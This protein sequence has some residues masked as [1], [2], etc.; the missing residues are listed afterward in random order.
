MAVIVLVHGIAQE[1]RTADALEAEWL[2]ALAGG[3]RLAGFPTLADRLW[4]DR[5]GPGAIEARMAFYGHLFLAADQQGEAAA[6]FAAASLELAEPLAQ[7][8]LE[9]A[10]HQASKPK[11]RQTALR[12][13]A[14]VRQT[15]GVEEMGPGQAVRLAINGL[16]RIRWFAP[17]G[18]AFAE[19]FVYRA[20][21]QVTRYF[22]D[23]AARETAITAVL[24]QVTPDT[25]VVIGHSLGS[26]VAYEAVHRL[27]QPLALLV[28]LGSPLGLNTLV[29]QRL[30]PP[31][32]FPPHV[33]HWINL[34]DW[35]DFIAAA[36][37]LTPL[38]TQGLPPN[39]VFE[40]GYTVDNGAQPHRAD[41]YLGKV[42]LGRVVA[43]ALRNAHL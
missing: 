21:S 7:E 15:A 26:V 6:E 29:Y 19:R 13:L 1:Q 40:G 10:A 31:P 12:E 17:L 34:A 28:T 23:E 9:R 37:D 41:F 35:D 24:A 43:Q 20:L 27:P 30:R 4:R 22:T 5:G 39:A 16:A 11:V 32:A 42:E 3:V 33:Q 18:M 2:P 38:F 8:W 36:P 14:Y 25:R